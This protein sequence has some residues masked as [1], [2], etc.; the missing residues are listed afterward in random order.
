MKLARVTLENFRGIRHLELPLDS[1]MNILVGE[2]AAGKTSLLD[3]IAIGLA[4]ITQRFPGVGGIGFKKGDLQRF[5]PDRTQPNLLGEEQPLRWLNRPYMRV[6]LESIDGI[7]WD[8]TERRDQTQHTRQELPKLLGLKRLQERIDPLIEA[9]E[10]D[11]AAAVELPV[12]VYYGTERAVLNLPQ[13]MR[14]LRKEF[15]RY[16]ALE[17]SPRATTNYKGVLEWFIAQENGELR[18]Q[19]RRKDWDYRLPALEAVRRAIEKIIPGGRDPHTETN[20]P[21][22]LITLEVEAGRPETLYLAQLSDGYRALL[23]LVMDL[24]R[25]M[26]QA[27]PHCGADAINS[28]AIVL[29]DEVDLH[30]HPRWQQRVLVDLNNTFPNAQFIVTTHSPQVL[31]SIH[32]EQIVRLKRSEEGIVAERAQSSYGAESGRLLEEIMDVDR[33]P[34]AETNEF[35]KILMDYLALI[36]DGQGE[37]GDAQALRCQLDELSPQDPALLRA[38]MEI[39]RRKLLGK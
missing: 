27:N 2:N 34:P 21:R 17:N 26:A 22:F 20:P 14:N 16:S 39:R 10:A 13:R 31:T 28:E 18:E 9:I 36:K 29:I 5:T 33:R 6:E 25:R 11:S 7:A 8:R 37:G 4:A 12:L 32:P 19:R 1:H 23:A 38:D 3:G 24:A 35:T 30:L 15:T